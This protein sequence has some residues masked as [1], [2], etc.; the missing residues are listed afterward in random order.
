M[1]A[2]HDVCAMGSGGL[3][4]TDDVTGEESV[5]TEFAGFQVMFHVSTLLPLHA[6]GE[7]TMTMR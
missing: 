1:R 2:A 5:F 3:N 6:E 4:V 7:T